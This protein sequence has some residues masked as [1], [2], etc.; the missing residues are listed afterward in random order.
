MLRW[1]TPMEPICRRQR[2]YA[3][4]TGWRAVDQLDRSLQAVER[5]APSR[6]APVSGAIAAPATV[7]NA[8]ADALRGVAVTQ[9][10]LTPNRVLE[11]LDA[12]RRG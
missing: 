7:V 2:V 10:P 1:A 11:V 12:Q 8:V 3:G 4:S 9:L 6:V 5:V